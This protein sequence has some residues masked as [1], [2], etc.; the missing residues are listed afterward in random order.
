MD[1]SIKKKLKELG[2]ETRKFETNANLAIEILEKQK[3][4]QKF[5]KINP[6]DIKVYER[7]RGEF[8]LSRVSG[9]H[10]C[11]KKIEGS[12]FDLQQIH[13]EYSM[14]EELSHPNLLQYLYHDKH[15]NHIRLFNSIPSISLREYL[16]K[17]YVQDGE[18]N[19][20]PIQEL[21]QYALEIAESLEFLHAVDIIH[22]HIKTNHIYL[23]QMDT[24]SSQTPAISLSSSNSSSSSQNIANINAQFT[25][26]YKI[27]VNN[28]YLCK[29]D[30]QWN[31]SDRNLEFFEPY[32]S[33]PME[34]RKF[35][36]RIIPFSQP[37][38]FVDAISPSQNFVF[39]T[40]S[41]VW[42]YGIVLYE[43]LTQRAPYEDVR[44]EEALI[45][46]MKN[47]GPSICDSI[48]P[49]PAVKEAYQN[50]I[51]I[52]SVCT[53]PNPMQR[54]PMDLVVHSIRMGV[55]IKELYGI[56]Q[57]NGGASIETP[58]GFLNDHY[59]FLRSVHK[60]RL[61]KQ[62]AGYHVEDSI[63]ADQTNHSFIQYLSRSTPYYQNEYFIHPHEN[64]IGK[65][66]NND[67][68]IVS[69]LTEGVFDDSVNKYVY[70][71]M[72][73]TVL[74]DTQLLICAETPKDR[75]KALR[76]HPI[77]ANVKSLEIVKD[78]QF[79]FDL[80]ELEINLLESTQYKMGVIYR[81]SGQT[82]E[83]ELFAN[84]NYSP[85][86]E[87]FLN[88]LGE[89]ITLKGWKK[90]RGG[91][92][93]VADSTGT[94]SVYTSLPDNFE[95]IFH[96]STLLPFDSIS[97]QQLHRKRHIGNDVV[98]IIFQDSSADPFTP[99]FFASQ[100]NHVF[101]VVEPAI[102]NN[103]TNRGGTRAAFG[104]RAN[105]VKSDAPSSFLRFRVSI[106]YKDSI[107]V[108][109][110]PYLQEPCLFDPK[111]KKDHNNFITKCLFSFIY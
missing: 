79:S 110:F 72:V 31:V 21:T 25:A 75:L 78:N 86:F 100:F 19:L 74:E 76:A 1:S 71:T 12:V 98:V 56:K 106:A 13:A 94:N 33:I 48:F 38:D 73:R 10:C 46:V 2:E 61:I 16:I 7:I 27:V 89:R 17:K 29:T 107:Q 50:I 41:D 53:N 90:F 60:S 52:I 36:T 108:Q 23:I 37:S 51:D 11:L 101:V 8:N 62:C 66:A 24:G 64:I 85:E 111:E 67:I 82:T 28:F 63:P 44:S 91:L 65:S 88:F 54:P 20:I 93:V 18:I 45:E 92:D 83:D 34:V 26:T 77:L 58:Q 70:Q 68:V 32:Y 104:S 96:V 80:A 3:K 109:S 69:M 22:R 55:N 39:S 14:M 84:T 4:I 87:H 49:S 81:K 6:N 42:S 43:M 57:T 40:Q 95:L 99:E 102:V 105:M 59:P 97:A 9:W 15:D 47:S 5:S 35:L 103:N 30:S